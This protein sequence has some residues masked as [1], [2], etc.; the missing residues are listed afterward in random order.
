MLRFKNE[1][2][3]CQIQSYEKYAAVEGCTVI[4]L[5]SCRLGYWTQDLLHIFLVHTKH[6]EINVAFKTHTTKTAFRLAAF[7]KAG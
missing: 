5:V 3:R 7:N 4:Y 1:I 6:N 2:T